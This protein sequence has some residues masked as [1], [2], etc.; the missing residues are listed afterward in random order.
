MGERVDEQ[1]EHGAEP[2]RKYMKQ[3]ILMLSS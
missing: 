3:F 2:P 1:N